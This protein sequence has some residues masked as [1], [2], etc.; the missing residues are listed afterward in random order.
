MPIYKPIEIGF[1]LKASMSDI[2]DFGWS[3][4]G[5][6]ADFV[7][8]EDDNHL[9]RV[10]F[11]TQ[12]IV[13]LLDEFALSTENEEGPIEGLVPEHFAYRIDGATFAQTQSE[14]WKIAAGRSANHYRFIIGW[15]CLD[16]LSAGDPTFAKVLSAIHLRRF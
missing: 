16:V 4:A 12:C 14:A 9:L 7:L 13:R 6:R 1:S 2:A 15:T 5:I 11:D 10:S 8:P 3:V